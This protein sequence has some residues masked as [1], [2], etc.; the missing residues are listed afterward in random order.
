MPVD[1]LKNTPAIAAPRLALRPAEAAVAL[2]IGRRMLWAMT[3]DGTLPH[4][5]LGRCTLYPT[6]LLREWLAE[7]AQGG[8]R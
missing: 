2:G 3:V 7:Q 6:D 5:K 8:A 4:V 1:P